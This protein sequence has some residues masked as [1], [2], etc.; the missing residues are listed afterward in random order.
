MDDVL[1]PGDSQILR[2]PWGGQISYARLG[3]SKEEGAMWVMFNGTPG[4][5]LDWYGYHKYAEGRGI[6]LLCIDRPG[7]GHSTVW[8]NRR[9]LDFIQDV[10]YLLDVLGVKQF[11]THGIS[12]GG[13]YVLAATYHFPPNRLLKSSIMC[14][15]TQPEYEKVMTRLHSRLNLLFI[16]YIPFWHRLSLEYNFTYALSKEIDKMKGDESK[17]VQAY[18]RYQECFRQG[19]AGYRNDMKLFG[20]DWGFDLAEMN[21]GPIRWYHGNMD[22]NISSSAARAT[23]GRVNQHR[24]NIDY[25]EFPGLDHY[26]LQSKS[27]YEVLEWLRE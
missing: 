9:M 24:R 7:Y 3:R 15:M 4:C 8:E 6:R 10:E 27:L 17:V 21:A 26:E 5:R 25:K 14:G 12:G 23:M 18:A 13:P 19:L 16:R 22:T 20:R 1:W 11:K 2:L